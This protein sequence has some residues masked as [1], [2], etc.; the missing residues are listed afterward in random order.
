QGSGEGKF[1]SR[2]G[3]QTVIDTAGF[4]P[5]PALRSKPGQR[6]QQSAAVAATRDRDK[7]AVTPQEATFGGALAA[8]EGDQT[9]T[10]RAR[11]SSSHLLQNERLSTRSS[12]TPRCSS[13]GNS[14]EQVA[15]ASSK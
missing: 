3:S 5:Q 13:L 1:V 9:R 12:A 15:V 2:G 6:V 7:N 4:K 14:S 10:H 8:N 11:Q